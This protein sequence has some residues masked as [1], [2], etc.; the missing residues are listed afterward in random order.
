M[1]LVKCHE[2]GQDVSTQAKAC[3]TCGAQVKK[4]SGARLALFLLVVLGVFGLIAL[5]TRDPSVR[6]Q[7]R[8]P[9]PSAPAPLTPEQIRGPSEAARE[10][11]AVPKPISP[12]EQQ[13]KFK[14]EVMNAVAFKMTWEKSGFGT[15]LVADVTLTNTSAHPI[16][17]VEL[18]CLTFAESGTELGR[19]RHT[20]YESFTPKKT[21]T[22]R[23][24]NMGFIHS[25]THKVG[26]VI[27]D[28]VVLPA[29]GPPGK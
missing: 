2:C 9:P 14:E 1:A 12:A 19:T 16:K 18:F 23:Q 24:T 15:V 8:Q 21:K 28:L 3:P 7:P 25:Q 22:V 5:A 6:D 29:P 13:R 17:D 27:S 4:P 26:C 20:I 10:I 11:P